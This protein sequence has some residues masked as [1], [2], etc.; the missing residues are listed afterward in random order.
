[1]DEQKQ[2]RKKIAS[3]EQVSTCS[4]SCVTIVDICH[5][6]IINED[7]LLENVK[8]CQLLVCYLYVTCMSCYVVQL[9]HVVAQLLSSRFSGG[10]SRAAGRHLRRDRHP[11]VQN[12]GRARQGPRD[13]RG[14]LPL[15]PRP[16][17]S[18]RHHIFNRFNRFQQHL[19]NRY[20]LNRFRTPCVL[21]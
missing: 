17:G 1:M 18:T 6:I 9:S 15:L 12:G 14:H 16:Q 11:E 4:P 7:I 21:Q 5:K 3:I 10:P 13:V 2:I 8:L 19:Q 20:A